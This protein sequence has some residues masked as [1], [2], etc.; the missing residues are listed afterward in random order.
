MKRKGL[1]L[2]GSYGGFAFTGNRGAHAVAD[3]VKQYCNDNSPPDNDEEDHTLHRVVFL[4]LKRR[5]FEIYVGQVQGLEVDF[6][7]PAGNGRLHLVE[8]KATKTPMPAMA[9]PMTSLAKAMKDKVKATWLVH[10]PA[11][12]APPTRALSPGVSAVSISELVEE[13]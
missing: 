8:A 9:A 12:T 4:E 5:G 13:L 6:L 10:R 2:S 3:K 1:E 11:K 7:V